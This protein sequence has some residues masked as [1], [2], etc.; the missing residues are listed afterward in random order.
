MSVIVD[1]YVPT[2]MATAQTWDGT[3]TGATSTDI[4]VTNG[5]YTG[6]YGGEFTYLGDN[7]LGTLNSYTQYDG[8]SLAELITGLSLNATQVEL[9]VEDNQLQD[10]DQLALGTGEPTISASSGTNVL[11]GY[12]ANTTF[13]VNGGSDTIN[14][15]SGFNTIVYHGASTQYAFSVTSGE[16]TVTDTVANR[17]G[18]QYVT[19]VNYLQFTDETMV[20]AP[21]VAFADVALLYPAALGRLPDTAGLNYWETI[22]QSLPASDQQ[23][24][25][26]YVLSD[27]SGGYNGS[28]SIAA[29]F[30]NSTEFIDKYGSLTNAQF[31]TQLYENVLD[32]APDATGYASWLAELTS[33]V[34][35]EHVLVGFADSPEAI[36][37]ATM[38]FIG[39]S[40]YHAPW[41]IIT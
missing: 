12:G 41:L 33:G 24:L 4:T 32:R 26:A 11:L 31:V 16:L 19:N 35:R 8:A 1:L 3:I 15:G 36:N 20:V 10:L 40:G 29:G 14:G 28:L 13:V 37:D 9:L 2:D 23:K 18:V 27:V 17:D 22:Y 38:G 21:T 6:V 30:T 5:Y 25:G 34:G 7:V 39:Q